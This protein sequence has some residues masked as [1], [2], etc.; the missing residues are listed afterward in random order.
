MEQRWR[1]EVRIGKIRLW[2]AETGGLLS[3][4]SAHD[5]LVLAL[6][7]SPEGETLASGG[8]DTLVRLWNLESKHLLTILR[9]H[10]DSVSALG[11]SIDGELLVSGGRDNY[12]QLWE[13]SGGNAIS[14]FPVQEGPI[15]ELTFSA[16]GEKLICA[17][18][19]RFAFHKRTMIRKENQIRTESD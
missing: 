9:G 13:T 5:G 19:K 16:D 18:Q 14:T 11:F 7:F 4:F 12:I 17:T 10:T 2:E 8:S 1:V 6:A 3:T 15:R